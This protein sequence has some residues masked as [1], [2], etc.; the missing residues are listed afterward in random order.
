MTSYENFLNEI[1][2]C[3]ENS[4]PI[5]FWWRDDDLT[6]NSNQF[7]NLC[8]ISNQ[9]SIPLLCSIIPKLINQNLKLDGANT[10][11]I[12]Y[13]QHGWAHANHEPEGQD[14]CE[15]GIHRSTLDVKADIQK[16]SNTLINLAAE[17]LCSVFVPPWNRFD[18]SHIKALEDLGFRYLS[19][20][21]LGG[22]QIPSNLSVINTHIDIIYW[23]KDGAYMRNLDE[24]YYTLTELIKQYQSNYV[25]NNI[26]EAI[27]I[28]SHHRVMQDQ[29]FHSLMH[30]MKSIQSA[31]GTSFIAPYLDKSTSP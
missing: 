6:S 17:K 28:L 31:K 26:P 5:N 3:N 14:K 18:L 9:L 29:E 10:N 30:L 21:G 11:F 22:I 4:I 8:E 27:G 24:I 19:S 1:K 12:S 2:K 16:G 20:Y 15:F 7:Q 25:K 23:G 13:C